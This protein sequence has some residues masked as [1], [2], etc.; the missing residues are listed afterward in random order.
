MVDGAAF[1]PALD[2]L[3]S[4]T[5]TGKPASRALLGGW[6]TS[7]LRLPPGALH[8]RDGRHTSLSLK[9]RIEGR[10]AT[11]VVERM[12]GQRL[13]RATASVDDGPSFTDVLALPEADPSWALAQALSGLRCDQIYEDAVRAGLT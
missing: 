7:R 6:L 5:V 11:F 9:G 12:P 10:S 4:A 3:T 1:R 2:D 13:V 8:V